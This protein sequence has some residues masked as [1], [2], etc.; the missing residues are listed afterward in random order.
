MTAPT[1]IPT[2]APPAPP[3]VGVLT[4]LKL[5]EP[6]RLYIYSVALVLFTG[7]NLAGYL[8]G[9]WQDYAAASAATLLGFGVA[10]ESARASVYSTRSVVQAVRRAGGR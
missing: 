9:A 5:T 3:S 1:P 4:R 6:V 8:T 7:L 10:G 2:P